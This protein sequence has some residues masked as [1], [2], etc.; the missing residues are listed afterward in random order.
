M[1][2]EFLNYSLSVTVEIRGNKPMN[3]KTCGL[4][5]NEGTKYLHGPKVSS[6]KLLVNQKDKI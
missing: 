4:K 1:W 2:I 6:Q 3:A 5:W